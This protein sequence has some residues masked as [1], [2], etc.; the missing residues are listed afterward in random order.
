MNTLDSIEE[1]IFST[2]LISQLIDFIEKNLNKK[3]RKIETLSSKNSK[4]LKKAKDQFYKAEGKLAERLMQ[5]DFSEI[6]S[7][8]IK[9]E[10][11]IEQGIKRYFSMI[12]KNKLDDS[13][14]DC[15]RESNR[16]PRDKEADREETN[17]KFWKEGLS[18]K[19][20]WSKPLLTRSL[21][22]KEKKTH[23]QLIQSMVKLK[24]KKKSRRSLSSFKKTKKDERLRMSLRKSKRR[25]PSGPKGKSQTGVDKKM[26][27]SGVLPRELKIVN[28]KLQSNSRKKSRKKSRRR[29]K[30]QLEKSPVFKRKEPQKKVAR[31]ERLYQIG[32]EKGERRNKSKINDQD[33]SEVF[34][35]TPKV[36]KTLNKKREM[37]RK[38][39]R[40]NSRQAKKI[41]KQKKSTPRLLAKRKRGQSKSKRTVRV[42]PIKKTARKKSQRKIKK[43]SRRKLDFS[44]GNKKHQAEICSEI[45]ALDSKNIIQTKKSEPDSTSNYFMGLLDHLK[46]APKNESK[47]QMVKP[48]TNSSVERPSDEILNIY[49][50]DNEGSL[51]KR[52]TKRRK[53]RGFKFDNC[54]SN[55][56]VS[57]HNTEKR[58]DT[59]AN[60]GRM[61]LCE[62]KIENNFNAET[63]RS[64]RES[65]M[66]KDASFE[67]EF[68]E[69][70]CS[71][72]F[73]SFKDNT[74]KSFEYVEKEMICPNIPTNWSIH[75]KPCMKK[76]IDRLE[77]DE[78]T[79]RQLQE[80]VDTPKPEYSSGSKSFKTNT[81]E[82]ITIDMELVK[83]SGVMHNDDGGLLYSQSNRGGGRNEMFNPLSE[84]NL[85]SHQIEETAPEFNSEN[86]QGTV[87]KEDRSGYKKPP[88][89][90]C[91]NQVSNLPTTRDNES[92][93]LSKSSKI[94]ST[95]SSKKTITTL[96]KEFLA[97][98][99]V[100]K[101]QVKAEEELKGLEIDNVKEFL[102]AS[103]SERTMS[104]KE[105]D[106]EFEFN[107]KSVQEEQEGDRK[108]ESEKSLVK[109][110]SLM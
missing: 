35:F 15:E 44:D 60:Q 93:L 103:S 8:L 53:Q 101:N 68:S 63:I 16:P 67:R 22:V 108:A 65:S 42:P 82:E 39:S 55:E 51:E 7:R 89:N 76:T 96:E 95:K 31:W 21:V 5:R 84:R 86:I 23:S 18:F 77:S 105:S 90:I 34:T 6:S 1:S 47:R 110:V 79:L 11:N 70:Y 74:L 50:I 40:K 49:K 91:S 26:T 33:S 87:K 9:S 12:K 78:D 48:L 104:R 29:I 20:T 83:K 46:N 75:R 80:Q 73:L 19:R 99:L 98:S 58:E 109:N 25:I 24:N 14:I 41:P 85:T 72:D 3:L 100:E 54:Y 27:R 28:S 66:I 102:L 52:T 61:P 56:A 92:N 71:N 106:P 69:N 62:I 13:D 32:V 81:I 38:R 94:F 17:S 59:L 30:K 57:T 10:P 43:K 37:S 2:D 4:N 107:G 88:L 36:N 64:R 97:M 45:E